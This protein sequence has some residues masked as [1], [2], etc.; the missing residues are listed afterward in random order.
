MAK[1]RVYELAKAL[2]VESNFVMGMLDNLGV[3][4]PSA[5]STLEAPV[6]RKLTAAL[7]GDES[8]GAEGD[9][10]D[11]PDGWEEITDEEGEAYRRYL[12]AAN[13][14]DS[15]SQAAMSEHPGTVRHKEE[16]SEMASALEEIG[17]LREEVR[18]LQVRQLREQM[19]QLREQMTQLPD[20]L[21]PRSATT[22]LSIELS[23][24]RDAVTQLRQEM[25][26]KTS[27]IETAVRR[28]RLLT[29][30]S[31]RTKL[32]ALEQEV[33]GLRNQLRQE[34]E[35]KSSAIEE[36]VRRDRFLTDF[37]LRTKVTALE[38][39]VAGLR[40]QQ[41]EASDSSKPSGSQ[42]EEPTYKGRDLPQPTPRYQPSDSKPYRYASDIEYMMRQTPRAIS[43]WEKSYD[44]Y[45]DRD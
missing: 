36:A 5:S 7:Q 9:A 30:V 41:R 32:T 26:E 4:V 23:Q 6:L 34:M 22:S 35:E 11:E 15:Q 2:G 45:R 14:R 1:V 24:L 43:E 13:D 37:S 16:A 39:E 21:A 8:D 29:D 12:H 17:G 18:Q 40:N 25:E 3:F 19:T 31:L 42:P 20:N 27:A 33:A 38:Q 28:N 44:P 10:D